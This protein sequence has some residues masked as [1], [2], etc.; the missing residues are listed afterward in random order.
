MKRMFG[1][2]AATSLLLLL[3]V[4]GLGGCMSGEFAHVD[5]AAFDAEVLQAKQPVIVDFYK[6]GCPTCW[7]VEGTMEQLRKE[8]GDRVKF[9]RF[10]A[11]TALFQAPA[12]RITG[13]Y[14]IN[15]YPTVILFING[16][17]RTRWSLNYDIN[18]YRAA[19]DKALAKPGATPTEPFTVW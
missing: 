6:D 11:M 7:L 12:P 9:F 2:P 8:Y 5:G 19:L 15:Y 18:S 17:E 16:Q 4:F 10:R 1:R 3:L 14:N 13:H